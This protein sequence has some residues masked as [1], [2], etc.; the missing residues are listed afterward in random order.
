[1]LFRTRATSYESKT[2]EQSKLINVEILAASLEGLI[3]WV[4]LATGRAV[5]EEEGSNHF[6][7]H[8]LLIATNTESFLVLVPIRALYMTLLPWQLKTSN[9]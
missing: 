6:L 7:H 8:Q 4:G 2:I 9:R 3:S 1:M 5:V